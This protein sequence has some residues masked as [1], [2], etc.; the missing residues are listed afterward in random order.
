[1]LTY[2]IENDV[3]D[4]LQ[5][6]GH[7][8]IINSI[9]AGGADTAETLKGIKLLLESTSVK[10]L[11]WLNPF[12]GKLEHNGKSIPSLKLFKDNADRIIN[13]IHLGDYPQATTGRDIEEM[14]EKRITFDEAIKTLFIMPRSRIHKVKTN[15]WSH[16]ETSFNG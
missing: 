1:M 3:F 6:H 12:Q 11:I 9:V 5:S 7:E 8:P 16:L 10:M 15:L 13:M 4:T 2:L 14:L